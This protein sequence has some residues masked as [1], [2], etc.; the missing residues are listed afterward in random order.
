MIR[1][2]SVLTPLSSSDSSSGVF[3]EDVE[4]CL[5]PLWVEIFLT[6]Y[7]FRNNRIGLPFIVRMAANWDLS[8][9]FMFPLIRRNTFSEET[10]ENRM[11]DFPPGRLDDW[12][13]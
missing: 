3:P 8:L 1:K 13:W 2:A 6:H 7:K 10:E 9:F 4:S 12:T 11:V 5:A